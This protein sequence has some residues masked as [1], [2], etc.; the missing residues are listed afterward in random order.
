MLLRQIV[1]LSIFLVQL[2]PLL[3]L[4]WRGKIFFWRV[5]GFGIG[6]ELWFRRWSGR[7]MVRTWRIPE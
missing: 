4:L 1:T 6:R 3:L 7:L 2:F 5:I